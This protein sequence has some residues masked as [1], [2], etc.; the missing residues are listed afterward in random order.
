MTDQL[1]NIETPT[2]DT[3]IEPVDEIESPEEMTQENRFSRYFIQPVL[4]SLMVTALLG[5]L[6]SL[7]DIGVGRFQWRWILIPTFLATLE[8]VFTAIWLARPDQRLLNKTLYRAAEVLLITVGLRIFTWAITNSWPQF[9][10]LEAYLREPGLLFSDP[11][12]FGSLIIVLI[13]WGWALSMS[14]G[15]QTLALEPSEIR[16]YNTPVRD[17]PTVERPNTSFRSNAFEQYGRNFLWGGVLIAT[18]A[19]LS[20][21]EIAD[22]ADNNWRNIRRLPF[23][24]GMLSA[25]LVYFGAGLALLSQAR[26][27]LLN[28]RWLYSS[29]KKTVAI[30]HG[31]AR[32]TGWILAVVGAIAAFLPLGST[33]LIGR[34]L[35]TTIRLLSQAVIFLISLFFGLFALLFPDREFEPI[36]PEEISVPPITPPE[37]PPPLAAGEPGVPV[38]GTLFWIAA[39]VVTILAVVFFLRDRGIRIPMPNWRKIWNV[40]QNW[41]A[42]FWRG[43]ADQAADIR[44]A[45]ITRL[46]RDEIEPDQNQPWRFIRLNSLSPRQKLRYFYLSTVQRAERGELAR[47]DNETPLE[48]AAELKEHLPQSGAAIDAVTAGFLQARYD[49][50]DV[51]AA[52]VERIEPLWKQLRKSI[53][54]RGRTKPAQVDENS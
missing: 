39:I 53:K 2:A 5:A 20:T 43:V 30:E 36:G 17:R 11:Y 35:E 33:T 6:F 40:L 45:V 44:D 47:D 28:S 37:P 8:G 19:A 32:Q 4:I 38:I 13:G 21:L 10:N 46:V 22:L 1:S 23:P 14:E 26:L 51:S 7:I 48:Y 42:S 18:F 50:K 54:Q 15:F 24:P 16:F 31:W 9:S 25:L 34:I 49:D 52:D 27:A 3:D 12:F 41:W 29:A